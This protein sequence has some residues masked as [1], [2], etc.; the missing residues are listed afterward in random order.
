L[1]TSRLR[2]K[3]GRKE[4]VDTSRL[5]VKRRWLER[6]VTCRLS[7]E[8]LE[9]CSWW[10]GKGAAVPKALCE[11]WLLEARLHGLLEAG[12]LLLLVLGKSSLHRLLLR[13][14]HLIVACGLRHHTV[15]LEPETAILLWE[16]GHLLLHWWHTL[17]V[18]HA[19]ALSR[20]LTHQVGIVT[21]ELR[22]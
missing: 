14:R 18:L 4:A 8:W 6:V 16:P 10:V 20:V 22:L 9:W 19:L 13:C 3:S 7:L 1:V 21:C 2:R 17:H 11:M 15:L 5:R 12:R